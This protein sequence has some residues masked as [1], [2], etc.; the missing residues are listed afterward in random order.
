MR[1]G[2]RAFTTCRQRIAITGVRVVTPTFQIAV[3]TKTFR[4]SPDWRK[5]A[6]SLDSSAWSSGIAEETPLTHKTTKT[7]F[8]PAPST[9]EPIQNGM[10]N[11]LRSRAT[12]S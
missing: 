11:L 1:P 12:T 4:L 3:I 10:G 8:G 7:S 6:L 2:L 9:K 5:L